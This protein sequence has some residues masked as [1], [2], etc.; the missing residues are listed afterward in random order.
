MCEYVCVYNTCLLLRVMTLDM[1]LCVRTCLYAPLSIFQCVRVYCCICD[2]LFV[3]V[4][5]CLCVCLCTCV[6]ASV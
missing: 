1:P 6:R 3:R 5:V 4:Y 2:V